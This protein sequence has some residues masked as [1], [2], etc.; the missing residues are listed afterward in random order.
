MDNIIIT[1]AYDDLTETS[2]TK[3]IIPYKIDDNIIKWEVSVPEEWTSNNLI[4]E[5]PRNQ[6]L[7]NDFSVCINGGLFRTNNNPIG[8]TI[9]NGNILTSEISGELKNWYLGINKDTGRF[10]CGKLKNVTLYFLKD[11]Y[12]N[13]LTSFVPLIINGVIQNEETL[14]DCSNYNIKNP[15]QILCQQKDG[16]IIIIFLKIQCYIL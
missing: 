15:R 10:E 2:Y 1:D 12:D 6:C 16:T 4:L 9:S 14:K 13:V 11:K 5:T 3:T 8:V 7:K